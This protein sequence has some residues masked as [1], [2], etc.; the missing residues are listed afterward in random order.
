MDKFPVSSYCV[1]FQT[2]LGQP[3]DATQAMETSESFSNE[4]FS[5]DKISDRQHLDCEY[6]S[7]VISRCLLTWKRAYISD[8]AGLEGRQEREA[9]AVSSLRCFSCSVTPQ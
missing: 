2:Y 9:I 3:R 1:A 7:H 6:Q 5:Q 4:E 8:P